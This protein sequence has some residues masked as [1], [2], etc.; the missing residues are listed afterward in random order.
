MP[1]GPR[2]QPTV[3]TGSGLWTPAGRGADAILDALRRGH[4]SIDRIA[5][6][7]FMRIDGFD[8]KQWIEP[9][10]AIKVMCHEIRLAFATAKM[11]TRDAKLEIGGS[12]TPSDRVGAVFASET[13]YSPEAFVE[14]IRQC[15]NFDDVTDDLVR[16]DRNYVDVGEYGEASMKKISPLWLLKYLP[17]MAA[18]HVGIAMHA[19]GPMNSLLC[20]D[21][22]G[23]ASIAEAVSYIQRGAADAVIVG[24]GSDR[25]ETTR[26]VYHLDWPSAPV[27][28]PGDQLK[29]FGMPG[30]PHSAAVIGADGSAALCLES[31]RHAEQRGATIRS[32]VLGVAR[33]FIPSDAFASGDRSH[34]IDAARTRTSSD[35][36]ASA[37]EA[38]VRQT[39]SDLSEIDYVIGHQ[40]GD[41]QT[42]AA[43]RDALQRFDRFAAMAGL[44]ETVGGT[45]DPP[46]YVSPI[47]VNGHA[48]PTT[49]LIAAT[50]ATHLVDSDRD[51]GGLA[52]VLS[53]TTEGAA[54][55]MLI[56]PPNRP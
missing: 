24:G 19:T 26:M 40:T 54:A 20:G 51:S 1:A 25:S 55:A 45:V 34:R 46:V 56:A 37:I 5:D 2:P 43:E 49:G 52:L 18:C 28:P 11:A 48:G 13:I 27:P 44:G 47:T 35:A 41:V 21:I 38:V 39:G 30:D 14:T 7:A 22:S 9:R 42:D 31:R 12:A 16:S 4:R 6:R 15:V 29:R 10:K 23:H 50:L 8:P 3:I 36:I 17:N 33:R 53:H 32:E